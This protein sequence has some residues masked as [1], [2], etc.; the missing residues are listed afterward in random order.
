MNATSFGLSRRST[1]KT[2][3]RRIP[4]SVIGMNSRS[5][6]FSWTRSCHGTRLAW[7]SISVRTM[8]SPRSMF[9]RPHEYETRLIA[10]V[11]LR[12]KM[13]SWLSGALMN[14]AT[15][16]ARLL[17][18][19]RRLLADRVDPAVDVGVVLAVVGVDRVDD[20]LRLLGRRRRSR[21]RRAGGRGSPGRG[22]GSRGG[23]RAGRAA[24]RGGRRRPTVRASSRSPSG[25]ARLAGG[26]HGL[27]VELGPL[28]A[29]AAPRRARR[30]T[31]PA[32]RRIGP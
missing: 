22:S 26:L 9:L 1:S 3:R 20:D 17:V 8:A 23:R 13:I 5:P 16:R 25:A 10:S 21:G 30:A 6:S 24:R 12:V 18:L 7:C 28:A 4:S 11:A 29:P 27:E 32:S 14:R 19:G 31:R 2:S 15:S